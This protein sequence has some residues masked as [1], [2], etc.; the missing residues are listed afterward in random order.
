MPSRPEPN[1][2]PDEATGLPGVRSWRAVYLI[3]FGTFLLWVML[4]TA[5]TRVFS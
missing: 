4:L 3:V 5:L 2:L 1:E